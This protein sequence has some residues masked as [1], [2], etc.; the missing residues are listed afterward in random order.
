MR[1]PILV[2]VIWLDAFHEKGKGHDGRLHGLKHL[3]VGLLVS[4]NLEGK[5]VKIAQTWDIHSESNT[6]WRDTLTI[7]QGSIVSAQYL[8]KP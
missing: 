8:G 1:K 5:S 7:P 3:S 6:P 2:K 4:R